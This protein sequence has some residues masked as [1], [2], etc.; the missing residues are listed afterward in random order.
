MSEKK[1]KKYPTNF[2]GVQGTKKLKKEYKDNYGE[3][4]EEEFAISI[5][6]QLL[7]HVDG[8]LRDR[9][10]SKF[11]ENDFEKA[12]RLVELHLKYADKVEVIDEDIDR[13]KAVC[14]NKFA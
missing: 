9:L 11:V 2:V 6:A 14:K 8:S 12:D 4:E 10:L 7:R 3:H 1:K 5:L 13:E